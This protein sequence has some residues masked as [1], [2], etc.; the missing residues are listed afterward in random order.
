M[1]SWQTDVQ[2]DFRGANTPQS[3]G[4]VSCVVR[5]KTQHNY[6]ILL[7]IPNNTRLVMCAMS[8]KQK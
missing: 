8:V 7:H 4:D 5:W 6:L 1:K 3:K 2:C